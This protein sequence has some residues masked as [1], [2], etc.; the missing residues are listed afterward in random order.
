MAC[1]TRRFSR[2]A[3]ASQMERTGLPQQRGQAGQCPRSSRRVPGAR[4]A[5]AGPARG[6]GTV[7]ALAVA[8]RRRTRRAR[9]V[10]WL[11]PGG[12]ARQRREKKKNRSER[13]PRP[14]RRGRGQLSRGFRA[15]LA[16]EGSVRLRVPQPSRSLESSGGGGVTQWQ[17]QGISCVGKDH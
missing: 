16:R 2:A 4:G 15:A 10:T 11:A 13:L 7:G 12:S 3:G 5:A 17:G 9:A 6:R 8:P 14:G 1:P